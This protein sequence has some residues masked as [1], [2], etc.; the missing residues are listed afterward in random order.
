MKFEVLELTDKVGQQVT[1][2]PKEKYPSALTCI[3]I[4]MFNCSEMHACFL[5][6]N[7]LT[8]T[9]YTVAHFMKHI[10]LGLEPTFTCMHM[11]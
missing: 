8:C 10:I 1:P 11:A 7:H 4:I 3:F 9:Y 5:M 2:L 6:N